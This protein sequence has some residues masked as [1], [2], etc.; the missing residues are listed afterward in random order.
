MPLTRRRVLS[1]AALVLAAPA[2]AIRAQTT[3]AP[4]PSSTEG[5]FYP[6]NYT[7][8]PATQLVRGALMGNAIPLALTGRI[9]DRF[10]KPVEG[11]RVEIWLA[12]GVGRYTHSRDS[13]PKDRDS[14][15][16]GFGW[17]R[18]GS[19]GAYA[20]SAI[21][22]VPYTGRTPH[23]HFAVIA[24]RAKKLVTQMFV[25]GVAQNERDTLYT[26]IPRAQ[27]AAVTAKLEGDASGQRASFDLV[28][29]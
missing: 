1:A 20:F 2:S 19:D 28:L 8:E 25:E 3:L 13:E 7:R 23:I 17:M 22:P 9:L 24:P 18:T 10:G 26:H 27:R 6:E 5:P 14:N 29:A 21:R 16:A 4:T 12:D 15:F 11:A